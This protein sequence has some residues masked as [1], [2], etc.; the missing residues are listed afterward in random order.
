MGTFGG[1]WTGKVGDGELS[2]AGYPHLDLGAGYMSAI[3]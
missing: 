1:S 2:V 3:I